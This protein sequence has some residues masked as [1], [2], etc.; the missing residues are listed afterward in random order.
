LGYSQKFWET[1]G[2]SDGIIPSVIEK[3]TYGIAAMVLVLQSRMHG[4]NLVFAGA[5]LLLGA[6]FVLAYFKTPLRTV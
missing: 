1:L 5:D 3:A 6:L 2:G 4:S